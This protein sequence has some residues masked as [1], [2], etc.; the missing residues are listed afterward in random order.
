MPNQYE[1]SSPPTAVNGIVYVG[2]AE[3]G[4]TLYAVDEVSGNLLWTASVANG[5]DSS[6]AVSNDGVFVTYPCQAYKFDPLTGSTLWHYSGGCEGG[7]GRTPAYANGLLYMR[8]WTNP[9]GLIFD[10]ETGTLTGN[11][12]ATPI[13]AFSM[14]TGFFLS[15]G[16]LS[17][18]DL[19]SHN[20]L[21]TF[22]GDGSLVS[23]PI[24]INEYVVIGSSSGNV[25]VLDAATGSQVWSGNAGS[26]LA[27]PD[28]TGSQALTGFGAGEGYLVV[29]AGNTLTAWHL[30][31]P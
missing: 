20:I 23:A 2:G 18:I 14:Q 19:S 10:A 11:F 12:T 6:P 1:F 24:I 27:A 29:P 13:P 3:S 22:T 25:Y 31:G 28:E 15:S 26:P 9:L 8:D 30:S 4:G 5:M 21:W 7:G 16:T 17:A